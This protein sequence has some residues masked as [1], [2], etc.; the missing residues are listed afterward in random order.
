MDGRGE[1][2]VH[3]PKQAQLLE[4]LGQPASKKSCHLSAC[5]WDGH[6]RF[7]GAGRA[8]PL[9]ICGSLYHGEQPGTASDGSGTEAVWKYD[10]PTVKKENDMDRQ[11][12]TAV[13]DTRRD[14]A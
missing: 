2:G 8:E 4:G 10:S 5:L 6:L 3:Q 7:L 12:D 1:H 11:R 9:W 13:D 14:V